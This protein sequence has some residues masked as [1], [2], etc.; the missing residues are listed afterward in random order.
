MLHTPLFIT[1]TTT[2]EFI[3]DTE[4][5]SVYKPKKQ[6]GLS[7]IAS[8]LTKPIITR[9]SDWNV[10]KK[11]NDEN[12]GFDEKEANEEHDEISQI[13]DDQRKYTKKIKNRITSIFILFFVNL[14]FSFIYF[15]RSSESI[16]WKNF[17]YT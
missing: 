4:S 5:I 11:I 2:T 15:S 12:K 9:S 10:S 1:R 16:D 13:S 7:A 17:H 14:F 3:I 6:T 8:S